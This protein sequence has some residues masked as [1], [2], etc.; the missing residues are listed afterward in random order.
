VNN[1]LHFA[2]GFAL[3]YLGLG[4]IYAVFGFL[5][6]PGNTTAALVL[7]AVAAIVVIPTICSSVGFLF[8]VRIFNFAGTPRHS[9]NLGL[10]C[11]VIAIVLFVASMSVVGGLRLN[12][13]VIMCLILAL[14]FLGVGFVAPHLGARHD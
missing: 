2:K 6:A 14:P 7:S 13:P 12:S 9:F 11:A 8:G 3:I 10:L 4:V 5:F 1:A